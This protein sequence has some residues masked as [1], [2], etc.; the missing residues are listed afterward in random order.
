MGPELLGIP[1]RLSLPGNFGPALT[2]GNIPTSFI[3]LPYTSFREWER[4]KSQ[5]KWKKHA[6]AGTILGSTGASPER[7][8]RHLSGARYR[9]LSLAA[10]VRD[11]TDLAFWGAST[12]RYKCDLMETQICALNFPKIPWMDN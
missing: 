1:G 7:V 5:E 3:C 6:T 12:S 11:G 10:T 4:R 9:F 2:V 8:W